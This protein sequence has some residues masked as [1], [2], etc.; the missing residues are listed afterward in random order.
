MIVPA[1]TLRALVPRTGSTASKMSPALNPNATVFARR[2]VEEAGLHHR[3]AE[4]HLAVAPGREVPPDR[5]TEQVLGAHGLRRGGRGGRRNDLGRWTDLRHATAFEDDEVGPEPHRLTEIV[6][7]VQER[8]TGLPLEGEQH[9][10]QRLSG[11]S[12]QGRKRLVQQEGRGSRGERARKRDSLTLASGKFSGHQSGKV[13][14]AHR[15]E[16]GQRLLAAPL[17]WRLEKPEG[18]VACDVEVG[19]EQRVLEDDPDPSASHLQRGR[20]ARVEQRPAPH[21]DL[22]LR[23]THRAQD[24]HQERALAGPAGTEDHGD[25]RAGPKRRLEPER[26]TFVGP[27]LD[28]DVDVEPAAHELFLAPRPS[29]PAP[30]ITAT[31]TEVS[32]TDSHNAVRSSP[33]ITAS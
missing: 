30:I 21:D 33:E 18:D 23:R 13:A 24:G 1:S 17:P 5:S 16:G 26:P 29:R 8:H 19:K 6:S 2:Y 25:P 10:A 14:G 27:A 28:H 12:I 7:D 22:A 32:S 15:L 31:E 4:I 20:G 11:R 3:A 9:V